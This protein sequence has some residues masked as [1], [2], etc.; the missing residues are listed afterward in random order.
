M[1]RAAERTDERI[2]DAALV[3]FGT[4]G[5]EATSLDAIAAVLGVR[6]QTILYWFPS[7]E[8]LLEAVVARAA[9]DLV[10]EL[11]RALAASPAG[12]ARL[13][14]VLGAVFRYGVRRPEVLGLV[15]EL[16]RLGPA[17]VDHLAE[18]LDP[19]VD[20]AVRLLE[21]EMA[22][23]TIRRADP[24]VLLVLLYATVVG[25]AIETEAQRVV[26]LPPGVATLRRIR[27]ELLA[28]VRAA[29]TP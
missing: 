14:A 27:R 29:L 6:K 12:L 9:G 23:G 24:R 4:R 16:N 19:L 25:V 5:Y 11:E 26:G 13:D 2:L 17:V 15:R 1:G 8:A 3:Q 10:R 21:A 18:H 28:F 7:K 22:A 20:R